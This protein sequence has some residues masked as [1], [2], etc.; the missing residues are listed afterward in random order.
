MKK[1]EAQRLINGHAQSHKNSQVVKILR[2]VLRVQSPYS[3][4]LTAKG[5]GYLYTYV[6]GVLKK[7]LH[8]ICVLIFLHN[9]DL[10]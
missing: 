1:I 9:C 4:P 5:W 3:H 8:L 7:Q 2:G 10:L 6:R